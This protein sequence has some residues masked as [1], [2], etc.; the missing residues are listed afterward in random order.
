[1]EGLRAYMQSPDGLNALLIWGMLRFMA[2]LLPSVTDA[3]LPIFFHFFFP[4]LSIDDFLSVIVAAESLIFEVVQF[5]GAV[6]WV[7]YLY[8]NWETAVRCS[9]GV[10][11][12]MVGL[13]LVESG[14]YIYGW[15]ND[16]QLDRSMTYAMGVAFCFRFYAMCRP[17]LLL[18][19]K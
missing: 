16:H 8:F 5:V 12:T 11:V 9:R 10:F 17:F 15:H 18:K 3:I 19:F 2:M 4:T 1:M 13:K 6:V 7:L 14:L